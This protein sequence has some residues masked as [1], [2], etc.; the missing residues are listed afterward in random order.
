MD[1]TF[2]TSFRNDGR[3]T[4]RDLAYA[5]KIDKGSKKEGID[6]DY[7]AIRERANIAP[8]DGKYQSKV[9]H[10]F[11][12]LYETNLMNNVRCHMYTRVR[13]FFKAFNSKIHFSSTLASLFPPAVAPATPPVPNQLLLD[14]LET[15]LG[16]RNDMD[17]LQNGFGDLNKKW[18]QN[19]PVI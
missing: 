3:G 5:L 14:A 9:M 15:E 1:R 11:T 8:H 16:Y 18:F 12:R 7:A 19:F 17:G 4:C 10:N 2:T 13:K 6:P